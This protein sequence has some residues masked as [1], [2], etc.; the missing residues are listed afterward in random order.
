MPFGTG[1]GAT[2]TFQLSRTLGGFVEPVLNV[3]TVTG[4]TANG[5]PVASGAY[6]VGSTG[7]VTFTTAPANSAALA[8]TGVYYYRCRFDQDIAEMEEFMKRFYTLK[9]LKFMGSPG[10]KYL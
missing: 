4:I 5:T 7:I 2:R 8:W 1:D 9:T 6:S 3:G 10:N